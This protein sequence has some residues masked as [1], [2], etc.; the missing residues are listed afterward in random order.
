MCV[1]I[2]HVF[3]AIV[4]LQWWSSFW[5]FSQITS[6]LGVMRLPYC[7]RADDWLK[8]QRHAPRTA[9]TP[10]TFPPCSGWCLRK[11]GGRR[12]GG[13][14]YPER[15]GLGATENTAKKGRHLVRHEPKP[16]SKIPRGR[17]PALPR[18]STPRRIWKLRWRPCWQLAST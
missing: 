15:R 17:R 14:G 13:S 4:N 3:L 5:S 16:F 9:V 2:E 11:D 7:R 1:V 10:R 12:S 6:P 18:L 8:L